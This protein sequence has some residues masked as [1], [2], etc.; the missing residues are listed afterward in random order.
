MSM[1]ENFI[2]GL[3]QIGVTDVILPFILVFTI[4]YAVLQKSKILGQDSKNFNVIIA[5]V[6]GLAVVIPHVLGLYGSPSVVDII[7]AALPQVSLI[8]IIIIMFVLIIG[9]FAKDVKF[10]G[11]TFT[12]W[13]VLLAIIALIMIFG[14]S[15]GWFA[16][17]SFLAFLSNPQLQ[18]LIVVIIVFGLIIGF[19]TSDSKKKDGMGK[20]IGEFFNSMVK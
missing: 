7:N 20:S 12:G 1:F 16:M 18:S 9:I 8:L 15:A 6:M 5:I 10:A 19:V 14:S 13:A 2:I 3:D 11:A 17:P 4:V